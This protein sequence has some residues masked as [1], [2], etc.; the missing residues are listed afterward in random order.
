[1]TTHSHNVACTH[2]KIIQQQRGEKGRG[3]EKKMYYI[4]ST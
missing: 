4:A 1:M 3:G 2:L